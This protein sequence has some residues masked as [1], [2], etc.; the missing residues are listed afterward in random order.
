MPRAPKRGKTAKAADKGRYSF[1]LRGVAI[2]FGIF[3][4]LYTVGYAFY[5]VKDGVSFADAEA[6]ATSTIAKVV[7]PAP[8]PQPMLDKTVYDAKML[9]LAHVNTASTTS[10]T[11]TTTPPGLTLIRPGTASTSVSAVHKLWPTAAPYPNYGALLP[12]NRI[13]AYYGNFY[14]TGMGV[15]GQYPPDEM[16][17]KLRAAVAEWQAADPKTPVIPAIDYIAVTAQGSPGKDMM[18]RLRMPDSQIDKALELASQV[19]GIV[20]LDVQ[21]GDSTVQTEV[22]LLEKYLKMPNVHLALDPEFD[23]SPGVKPGTVIGTMGATEI[24]WAANYLAGLVKAN[25]LPPKVLVIHRFTE[26]MVQNAENITP[27]PEVQVV[28]DMDGWGFGAKKINTYNTV[29]SPEPVQFTGFKLFYKNDLKPPSTRMLTP[30]EVLE[31]TPS[32]SF[33][34]YQ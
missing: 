14:S 25:N 5:F 23:M 12:A 30:A 3:L 28:M 13:V 7:K 19:N 11:S 29:V 24:N 6:A 33:I 2:G 4:V 8:P 10:D 26:G 17:V 32:P 22:P 31:L 27:L 15:L 20:I 9:F 21:V 34:Q 18:Y 16:L 1:V